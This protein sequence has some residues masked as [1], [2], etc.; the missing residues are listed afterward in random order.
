MKYSLAPELDGEIRRIALALGMQHVDVDRVKCIRSHGSKTRRTVAR[1]HAFPKVLQLALNSKPFYVIELL[2]EKFDRQSE[3]E[4]TKTLI[5]ELLHIP[6]NFGGGF[7]HHRPY[8][9]HQIVESAFRKLN[10]ANAP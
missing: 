1:I 6:H 4:K 2:S 10:A 9:N 3:E 8:V 7:R 5:H